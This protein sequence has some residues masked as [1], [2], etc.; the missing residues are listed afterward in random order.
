[1]YKFETVVLALIMVMLVFVAMLIIPRSGENAYPWFDAGGRKVADILYDPSWKMFKES[2]LT[3]P[4]Q[5]FWIDDQA[6]IL[7]MMAEDTGTFFGNITEII[8]SLHGVYHK[9]Y[10]PRR[11]VLTHP[12]N[13]SADP[14]NV[15][16]GNGFLSLSGNLTY[17][18]DK[19]N[20]FK[21]AY[22]EA[23]GNV[24]FC[25]LSGQGLMIIPQDK[26]YNS[27]TL[28]PIEMKADQASNPGFDAN[29]TLGLHTDTDL[30]PWEYDIPNN[31]TSALTP[32]NRNVYSTKWASDI[33]GYGRSIG[34]EKWTTYG[35][36]IDW[37]CVAFNVTAGAD[38]NFK[39]NYRGTYI[40]GSTVNVYLRWFYDNCT[41]ISQDAGPGY[42]SNVTSWTLY[43]QT[44]TAPT[45]AT[46]ADLLVYCPADSVV[47]YYF[48]NFVVSAGTNL[49]ANGNLERARSNT[50]FITTQ[51]HSPYRCLLLY[52]NE[53]TIQH[54]VYP[55]TTSQFSYLYW[56]SKIN[57]PTSY[58]VVVF[59][60]DGTNTT[61]SESNSN[62]D[63]VEQRL[64][65]NETT[66]GKTIESIGFFAK[67]LSKEAW[68]DDV[69]VVYTP[70]GAT[71][72][73]SVKTPDSNTI[74][75][76]QNYTDVNINLQTTFAF[77]TN[78]TYLEENMTATSYYGVPINVFFRFAFDGLSGMYTGEVHDG[79]DSRSYYDS[80]WIPGVGRK[81]LNASNAVN[82]LFHTG[83]PAYGNWSQDYFIA[84]LKNIPE[85]SGTLGLVA[86][87]DK[88]HFNDIVNSAKLG[89]NDRLDYLTYSMSYTN[90]NA[91]PVTCSSKIFCM[92]GYDW[93]NPQIYDTFF[94]D[95]T[96]LKNVD[97]SLSFHIG[98]ILFALARYWQIFG[99]DPYGM[100][101]GTFNY[102]K[103][104]F[105]SQSSPSY[106]TY[107]VTA[108]NAILGSI[109]AYQTTSNST[110]LD[111]ANTLGSYLMRIQITDSP[112]V[113]YGEFPMP[114]NGVVYLDCHGLSCAALNAL[115]A[116]N[117]TYQSAYN[118][119]LQ[120]I[121]YDKPPAGFTRLA[122]PEAA[123]VQN[124]TRIFVYANGSRIDDDFWCYKAAIVARAAIAHNSTLMMLGLSRVWY[125]VAWNSTG[126]Y[127]FNCESTPGI[128]PEINSETHPWGLYAWKKVAEWEKEN[129][130]CYYEFCQG[131]YA[132]TDCS[133]AGGRL[134]AE[135]YAPQ[136]IATDSTTYHQGKQKLSLVN[137][138]VDGSKL[139]ESRDINEYRASQNDTYLDLENESVLLVR[140]YP[141]TSEMKTIIEIQMEANPPEVNL[142]ILPGLAAAG[143]LTVILVSSRVLK[144]RHSKDSKAL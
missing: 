117:S 102:Y 37:R 5:S 39:Y 124:E 93:T 144:K 59:Y 82:T 50:Q 58:N 83:D 119:G 95:V 42:T 30:L 10:F 47:Q 27:Y 18:H 118:L 108:A 116:Y 45:G 99:S 6:K 115:L 128:T 64:Y 68:I 46:N 130:N 32:P 63:W 123:L 84:E 40:S 86:C 98:T 133:Y 104:M 113:R 135:V 1:M 92:N 137:V 7:N 65:A 127:I 109:L 4:T 91:T 122:G 110:Y 87:I 26:L 126:M 81:T 49:V 143:I 107:L 89:Y 77:Q 131:H 23:A 76:L 94:N 51:Y 55:Q 48:D 22:G 61:V 105:T 13:V 72:A 17:P 78:K 14:N 34:F 71:L 106:G 134:K 70:A 12:T 88:T 29:A 56:F 125:D 114:H 121:R 132:I 79:V 69:G 141:K 20:L 11:Y 44:F 2:S 138:S 90:L 67:G 75:G 41:W 25:L 74:Y 129:W 100:A 16:F 52:N 54:L 9:G 24:A 96:A 101:A 136:G 103:R 85:W 140:A 31:W 97:P 73:A 19:Y 43:N 120:A 36:S 3:Y 142:P 35:S 62:T 38:Y 111:F 53:F 66:P 57:L 139:S 60:T 8:N 33:L 112:D 21:L 15:N 80:V 28:D